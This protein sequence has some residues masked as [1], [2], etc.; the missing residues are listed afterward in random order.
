MPLS[1][2][3][4]LGRADLDAELAQLRETIAE[5]EAILSDDGRLRTVIKDEMGA[6]R[7][8]FA[9]PRRSPLTIDPGDLDVEDL[10]DDEEL[11]EIEADVAAVERAW[12]G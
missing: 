5:L 10:I 12:R 3:T 1:R 8:T 9:N 11:V 7:E 6:I 2:L 4:R